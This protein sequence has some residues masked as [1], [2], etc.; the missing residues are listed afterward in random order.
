M[1]RNTEKKGS[2]DYRESKGEES[3]IMV[4]EIW[5]DLWGRALGEGAGRGEDR[6]ESDGVGLQNKAQG[7][8]QHL[9]AGGSWL[10]SWRKES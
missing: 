9:Q 1:C 4:A 7:E 6:V 2:K 5:L 3:I 8:D 10:P